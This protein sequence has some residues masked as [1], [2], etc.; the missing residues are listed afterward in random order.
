MTDKK[1]PESDSPTMGENVVS[2]IDAARQKQANRKESE[3]ALTEDAIALRFA[4]CFS[5]LLLYSHTD[6]CW[7]RWVETHYRPDKTRLAFDWARDLIRALNENQSAKLAS[8]S[9]ASN[10]ERMAQADRRFAVTS[11][12]FDADPWLLGTPGGTVDLRTGE[13]RAAEM[14]DYITRTAAVAPAPPGSS[15]TLWL[16]FLA[17]STGEDHELMGFLQRAAG[18]G[19]TGSI[20]EHVLFFVY[21]PGG[22]GKSVVLNTMAGI[23]GDYAVTAPADTF[24]AARGERHPTDLAMLHRARLVVSSETEEGRPW[25]EARIKSM[26]GGDPITA[27]FMRRDF[28]TYRP[29]F[30]LVIV[31]NYRPVL[32]NVDDAVRRRFHIIPFTRR[33]EC[34]DR[35]LEA[36]LHAEWPA[37]LRWMIDGC[38]EWQRDGL[39]PPAVVTDATANYF[40]DQDLVGHWIEEA[41]KTGPQCEDTHRSLFRSWSKYADANGDRPGSARAFTDA[42]RKRGFDSVRVIHGRS[43]RGFKGIELVQTDLDGAQEQSP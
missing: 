29:T 11:E 28:F 10:V 14:K 26:T 7:Y 12:I 21:G 8:A 40:D 42:M 38:L 1:R 5:N 2:L 32:R 34:P 35:E 43:A 24:T 36:K 3:E 39:A 33:P 19:L 4:N 30:K 16:K 20:R 23:L 18:Y 27:R 9:T 13:L 41:C 31:G 37:I 22:N 25:A 15:P 6:G 17:E